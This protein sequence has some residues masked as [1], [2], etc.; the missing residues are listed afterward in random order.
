MADKE[1]LDKY[2]D[3]EKSCLMGKEKEEVMEM[4]YKYKDTFSLRDEIGTYPYIKV[5]I[6]VTDKFPF[7]IRPYHV[8]EE[9]KALIDRYETFILFRYS[10]RRFFSLFKSSDVDQQETHKRQE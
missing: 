9:D 8:K 3:L 4:L 2:I 7:F 1:I 5:E 10:E 6:E